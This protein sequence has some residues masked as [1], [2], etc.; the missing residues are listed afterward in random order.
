MKKID[1]FLA[2]ISGYLIRVI[3]IILMMCI[4]YWARK[5]DDLHRLEY[6]K[7][8]LKKNEKIQE[9]TQNWEGDRL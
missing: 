2:K 1:D 4:Y 7:E 8:E 5:Q 6:I 3:I 9:E